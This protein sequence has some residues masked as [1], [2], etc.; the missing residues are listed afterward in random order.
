MDLSVGDDR[1]DEDMF[2]ALN[3]LPVSQGVTVTTCTVGRKRTDAKYYVDNVDEVIELLE[4][5]GDV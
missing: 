3:Q 5:L 2:S 4:K 1:T